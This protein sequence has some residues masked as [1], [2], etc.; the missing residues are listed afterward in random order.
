M[1]KIAIKTS[2]LNF[3]FFNNLRRKIRFGQGSILTKPYESVLNVPERAFL[4]LKCVLINLK[5]LKKA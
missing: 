5:N 4:R 3:I 1:L 2:T